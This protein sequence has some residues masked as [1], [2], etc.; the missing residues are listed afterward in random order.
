VAEMRAL[1]DHEAL[2]LMEHRRVRLVE[3][4]R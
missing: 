3:S 1:V 2:D 4:L